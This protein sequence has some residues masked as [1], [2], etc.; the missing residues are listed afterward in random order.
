MQFNKEFSQQILEFTKK[1]LSGFK[2]E[3]KGE[4]KI[5]ENKN[6]KQFQYLKIQI[7]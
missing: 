2:S 7:S 3:D 1:Q 4:K 6:T 5:M